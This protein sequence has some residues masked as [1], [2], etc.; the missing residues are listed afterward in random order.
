MFNRHPIVYIGYHHNNAVFK[1]N[2]QL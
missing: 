2:G 1:Q